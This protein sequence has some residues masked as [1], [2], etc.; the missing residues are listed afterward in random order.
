MFWIK[1]KIWAE[2]TSLNIFVRGAV[3]YSVPCLFLGDG[4]NKKN[5]NK[6][7]SLEDMV[8]IYDI[9]NDG[10]SDWIIGIILWKKKVIEKL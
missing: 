7:V 5:I 3:K 6:L 8:V 4:R 10:Q 2:N 9:V 1:P